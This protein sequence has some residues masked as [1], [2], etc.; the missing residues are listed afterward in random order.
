MKETPGAVILGNEYQALGHLR[1]LSEQGIECVLVDQDK[2]GPA[3]FSKYKNKF[4][5]SPIYTSKEFW[6]WLKRL[7][8]ENN[9]V[10]WVIIPTDDEQ[11]R[12]LSENFEE[13]TR[14]F[15]HFTLPWD[16][17]QIIYNKRLAYKWSLEIGICN[18]TSY[19]PN[20][21][22]DVLNHNL[23]APFILK[24]AIKKEFKHYS[25]KKAI[26]I[27]SNDELKEILSTLLKNVPIEDLILQE[28]IKG[29]GEQQ[30]SYA[31]F[32]IKGLPVAAFT[33]CR[34]RQHPPD[35]GR[36]STYV[37]AKYNKDV[38]EEGMKIIQS[39]NYTGLAE[40][41]FKRDPKDNKLKFLEVNARSWGWH[42]ISKEVV[43]NI[44]KMLYD[45][46]IY[47]KYSKVEPHY[48]ARWVKWITDLPVAFN[49]L[50]Q[51]KLKFKEYYSSVNK[52]IV[53][54]ESD[55]NDIKPL[56]FQIFLL[57]YLISKRGY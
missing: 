6:P 17:Y 8:E 34:M 19:I 36:A 55:F 38:E 15:K 5:L 42:S 11:V 39:L 4:F 45:Y 49:L 10:G 46:L 40:V 51:R 53:S 13:V 57:P 50:K 44:T 18:P 33:A 1:F 29:G 3:L 22:S 48:G 32:F 54:C 14:V 31:G 9:Y 27:K 52:N 30:W 43:G 28:I 12:Q 56:F 21:S 47:G 35:Y 25:N 37:I 24:P 23:S 20:D 41:E 26:T 16:K 2:Y 7:A